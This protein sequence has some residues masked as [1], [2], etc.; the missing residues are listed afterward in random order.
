MDQQ[1]EVLIWFINF[2]HRAKVNDYTDP[3]LHG[4]DPP[5]YLLW[6]A[7]TLLLAKVALKQYTDLGARGLRSRCTVNAPC[8][9]AISALSTGKMKVWGWVICFPTGSSNIL[10]CRLGFP[11]FCVFP[12]LASFAGRTR[13]RTSQPE[14]SAR[15]LSRNREH[16]NKW[17]SRQRW[18]PRLQL[19]LCLNTCCAPLVNKQV[20]RRHR[21]WGRVNRQRQQFNPWLRGVLFN[22]RIKKRFQGM[23]ERY[24]KELYFFQQYI[25]FNSLNNAHACLSE[26]C[27]ILIIKP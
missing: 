21:A 25:C 24:C 13:C 27:I 14:S 7:S 10:S 23:S 26:E 15:V 16:F 6:L 18:E 4:K 17:V 8:L 2:L 20:F 3:Q 11:L 12:P 9:T 22:V 19:A 1:R 5:V